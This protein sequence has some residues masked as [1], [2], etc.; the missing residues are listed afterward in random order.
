MPP[1]FLFA[2]ILICELVL[3]YRFYSSHHGKHAV[4]FTW[5]AWVI[6]ALG[7]ASGI[8]IM[9]LAI[10]IEHDPGAFTFRIP[11]AFNLLLFIQGSWQTSIHAVKWLIR[12]DRRNDMLSL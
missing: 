8:I 10:Y 11:F 5:Y 4:Y 1:D 9:V 3:F 7:I 6:D 12:T 2:I